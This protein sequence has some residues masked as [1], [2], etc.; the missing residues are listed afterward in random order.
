MH[1]EF[2][3]YHPLVNFLF[4]TFVILLSMFF[5]HPITLGI[6]LLCSFAYSF[7]RDGRKTFR[8][9]FVLLPVCLGAA[10]INPLFSH[11]G[12]SILGYFPSGNPLTLESICY[13]FAAGGM[14]AAVMSWFSC[15]HRVMTG[16]KFIYLF[17]R[18]F[19]AA[20]L[21]LS[22]ILRFV[23]L[24][25]AR[26]REVFYS[27]ACIGKGSAGKSVK[28]RVRQGGVALSSLITWSMEHAM[29]TADSMAARGYGRPGRTS[30][31]IYRIARRDLAA[32]GWI[33]LTGGCSAVFGI[34]GF[35]S[36]YYFPVMKSPISFEARLIPQFTYL[37]LCLTPVLIECWEEYRWKY[38]RSRI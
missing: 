9:F 4:F 16:D 20:S 12:V 3:K 28:H 34:L 31:S 25:G 14:L 18:I 17:G 5:L 36:Y 27:R 11:E 6:S 21:L 32:L 1:H 13:G 38:W 30:Y 2:E 35:Y 26:A 29:E 24:F 22:M 37:L 33:L 15:Y 23:P 8:L 7:L 10:V 19:P